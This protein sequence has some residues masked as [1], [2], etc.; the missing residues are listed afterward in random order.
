[1]SVKVVIDEFI[2]K[3]VAISVIRLYIK[4]RNKIVRPS[5]A[6]EIEAIRRRYKT[7]IKTS[8]RRD[9]RRVVKM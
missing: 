2:F 3:I 7:Y 6:E 9:K 8:S 5:V 4:E 1:M